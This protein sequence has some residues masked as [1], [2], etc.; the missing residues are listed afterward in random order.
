M[1]WELWISQIDIE[2]VGRFVV[3]GRWSRASRDVEIPAVTY[4]VYLVGVGIPGSMCVC[5]GWK[6]RFTLPWKR[7]QASA[8]G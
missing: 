1:C 2:K 5:I 8:F 6:P 3:R 7:K 4:L